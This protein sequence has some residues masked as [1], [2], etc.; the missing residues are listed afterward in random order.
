MKPRKDIKV[1]D[2][3][4]IKTGERWRLMSAIKVRPN[5]EVAEEKAEETTKEGQKV[6]DVD[7]EE[8]QMK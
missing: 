2:K 5:G 4:I 1:G 6:E 7:S 3:M 8:E